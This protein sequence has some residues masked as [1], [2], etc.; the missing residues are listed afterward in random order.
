MRRLFLIACLALVS[1][2]G[3]GGCRKDPVPPGPKPVPAPTDVAGFRVLLLYDYN[4]LTQPRKDIVNSVPLRRA[5]RQVAAVGEK[6]GTEIRFWPAGIDSSND[7][8]TMK[9]LHAAAKAAT[10]DFVLVATDGKSAYVGPA[11]ENVP[12]FLAVCKPYMPT[13]PPHAAPE[14]MGELLNINDDNAHE[15]I[16]V[17]VDGD[18][19]LMGLVPR[20]YGVM[21]FGMLGDFATPFNLPIIPASDRKALAI[22]KK[23]DGT[24]TCDMVNEYGV[25]SLDQDGTNWCWFFGPTGAMMTTYAQLGQ[26]YIPLSPASGAGPLTGYRNVGGYGARALAKIVKDGICSQE[27]WPQSA[28]NPKYDTP[29]SR[30]NRQLHK[31]T[32]WYELHGHNGDELDTLL[33]NNIPVACDYPWW[34]HV[35]FLTDIDYDANGNKIYIG[36]NSWSGNWPSKGAGGWFTLTPSKATAFDA[37]VAPRVSSPSF[38]KP[39]APQAEDGAFIPDTH[40][41]TAA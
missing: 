40:Y 1:L 20:D 19:K 36:R 10:G 21:K 32:E 38:A 28:I 12:D 7:Y 41:A 4:A 22:K 9:S 11:P 29:E 27:L 2:P 16:D 24:R 5:L 30:A 26:P 3:C 37:A 8:P 17:T 34:S 31:I 33:L 14:P 39:A 18:K 23:A 13:A 25:L 35:V 6:G 15:F